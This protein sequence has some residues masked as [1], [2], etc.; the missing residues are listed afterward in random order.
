VIC[1]AL[2]KFGRSGKR[3]VQRKPYGARGIFLIQS[4]TAPMSQYSVLIVDD[5]ELVRRGLKDILRGTEFEVCGEAQDGQE[6]LAQTMSLRPTLVL[7]D[8]SMPVLTGLQAAAKIRQVLPDTKILI[9]TMH[10]S[11]QMEVE[12]RAAGADAYITKMA[13]AGSLVEAMRALVATSSP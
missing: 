11:P 7:L 12:A 6:G 9:I 8:M 13:A 4:K 10:D 3:A 1:N 5:H 2:L